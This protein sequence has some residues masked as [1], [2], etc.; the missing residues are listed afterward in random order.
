MTFSSQ[1]ALPSSLSNDVNLWPELSFW[2]IHH[3]KAKY[4]FLNVTLFFDW[5][6]DLRHNK[7]HSRDN[8]PFGE[9]NYFLI[10]H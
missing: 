1:P 4:F 8:D 10:G 9:I 5:G 2:K 6:V 7:F 3:T